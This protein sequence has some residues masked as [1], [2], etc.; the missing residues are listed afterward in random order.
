M[1]RIAG[2]SAKRLPVR[3]AQLRVIARFLL[4]RVSNAIHGSAE[5]PFSSIA[6]SCSV[7]T[8]QVAR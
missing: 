4:S 6:I 3:F 5:H 7:A 1:A 2:H 8:W